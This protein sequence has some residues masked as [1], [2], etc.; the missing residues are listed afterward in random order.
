MKKIWAIRKDSE[1]VSPVIATILMVAITVVLAAV[2]YVMVLGFGGTSSTPGINVLRKS[3]IAG[4][5][6]IEFTAPTAEVAWTDVTIQVSAGANTATWNT[7]TTELLTDDT[8]PAVFPGT[9]KD[10]GAL[11]VYLNVTDLAGNG[12]MSNGDYITLQVLGTSGVFGPSTTYTLTLLYEP[13][14]GSMLAYDFTG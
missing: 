10:V 1:A 4:G 9:A 8:P 14:D 7:M 6:K 13:T 12:R 11:S 3:S 2:L 5:F